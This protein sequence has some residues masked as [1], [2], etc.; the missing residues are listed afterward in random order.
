MKCV[1][2]SSTSRLQFQAISNHSADCWFHKTQRNQIVGCYRDCLCPVRD[3]PTLLV[4]TMPSTY[5]PSV[6]VGVIVSS[7]AAAKTAATVILTP[8]RRYGRCAQYCFSQE[9]S[10]EPSKIAKIIGD[11]WA[12]TP[13]FRRS[14][15]LLILY[16]N[17]VVTLL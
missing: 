1:G 9:M 8:A 16:V 14:S 11:L 7:K 6:A 2:D 12:R 13:S 4:S 5:L 10:L 17:S 3:L 15:L